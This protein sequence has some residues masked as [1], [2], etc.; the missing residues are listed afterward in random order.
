MS[1]RPAASKTSS[2]PQTADKHPRRK[3]FD[4][5]KPARAHRNDTPEGKLQRERMPKTHPTRAT[6]AARKDKPRG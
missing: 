5:P 4:D 1:T 6:S 3:P 2:N